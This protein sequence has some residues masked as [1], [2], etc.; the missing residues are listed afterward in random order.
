MAGNKTPYYF[1]SRDAD[2]VPWTK[3]FVTVLGALGWPTR[4]GTWSL[5][6]RCFPRRLWT[7][8]N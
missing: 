3:N 5:P 7:T 6:A 1:P 4:R 2:V 8:T